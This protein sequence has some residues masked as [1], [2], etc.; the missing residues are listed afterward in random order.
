MPTSYP[1]LT[2]T[3][4]YVHLPFCAHHCGYCD[5]A[6]A[7]GMDE[8][9][10]D[11]LRA[12]AA[13][14][15]R[16]QAPRPVDTLFFGGGTPTYLTTR[17]LET[18]LADVLRWLPLNPG[19]EFSVEA[20]P[21]TLDADKVKLLAEHGVTR[22]SLG[23]Q[24]FDESTLRVLERNH[25]P[26]DVGRSIDLLRN[27]D[28]ALS[29]DLIFGVPGQ[30]AAMWDADLSQ[31]L[32]F[33]PDGIATYGLTYEKGTRLWKQERAGQVQPVGEDFELAFYERAMD[34]LGEAGYLQY[35]LS[36]FARPARECRHNQAYWANDAH[37]GFGMGAAEYVDGERRLNTRDLSGYV[38]KALAG[39]STAFQT[40]RLPPR[41]RA[42]ET[43]GQNL[44]R[45]RGIERADFRMRTGFDLDRFVPEALA[46]MSSL[47]MIDDDGERA[48][49]TRRGKCVADSVIAEFWKTG[50]KDEG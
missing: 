33:E 23:C 49:L 34:R 44:R 19:H 18:C 25:R 36:N 46:R 16:L 39:E 47:G 9:R 10:G 15:T 13:E 42:L 50:I 5:F 14:L 12:L 17:E 24:S 31:V 43:I 3:A 37:F 26:A 2:P 22:V 28:L 35:E 6:V 27:C 7:V 45:L 48:Q 29:L 4:A 30:T 40:E 1:W 21:G 41:E 38:R 11:Y 32:A 20:N 8:R